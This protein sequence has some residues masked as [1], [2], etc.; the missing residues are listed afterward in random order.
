MRAAFP[1]LA[2]LFQNVQE[3][4]TSVVLGPRWRRLWGAPVLEEQVGPLRLSASP[5]AFLQVNTP[6]CEKLY[7]VVSA[8][9]T[10]DGFRPEFAADLYCGVG[11]IALW[12]ARSVGRVLG[13]EE[14]H[15]A[16]ADA[17]A[18]A[19]ANGVGNARF[20]AGRAETILGRLRDELSNLPPGGAAA[21]VDPPRAGVAGAVLK[22]LGAPAIGR[23]LYV[24]CN[25]A[26]FARD[27]GALARHGFRLREVQPVD[28]FP[29]T[30]HVE[31]AA[32]FDRYGT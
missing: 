10:A 31:L 29:Q 14:S 30:S 28:L 26:T 11:A 3:E 13:V 15:E 23:L 20:I 16:V 9:L 18:N 1:E 21:L 2:G 8:Q 5:G 19:R 12:V 4:R 7:D 32:R 25:P 27:A 22:A 6:A 17:W 24:S